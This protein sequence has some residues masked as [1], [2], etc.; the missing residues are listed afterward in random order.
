MQDPSL[1]NGRL[2]PEQIVLFVAGWLLC[3]SGSLHVLVWLIDGGSLSGPISWRKPILF[4]FSA[5]VTV[6]SMGWVIGKMQRRS[7]DFTLYAL[8][9]LAMLVEVVLI[10]LQQWRGVASHFNRA[11]PLDA[12]VLNWIEGFIIFAALVIAEITRRSY[13]K[14]QAVPEMALAIRSGM[15]LLLVSCLL[16]FVLVAYGNYRVSQD[17][18]PEVYPPSGVMKFPHGVPMHAIQF[19]PF[20]AWFSRKLGVEEKQR[21]R[22]VTVALLSVMA[23]TV[24]SLLQTFTGRVRFEL[25][26]L[27]ASALFISVACAML[28]V[29]ISV[30]GIVRQVFDTQARR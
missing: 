28:L 10:T 9:A 18:A 15:G 26:W 8:F 27:S 3:A 7:L 14:L 22:A 25:W 1:L 4:G 20:V 19:L 16:G 24:F 2:R 5:G 21:Y 12:A 6:L 30:V 11:T 13:R 23:F 29:C 17:L